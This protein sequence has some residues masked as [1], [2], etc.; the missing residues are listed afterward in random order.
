M[1][2]LP[3]LYNLPPGQDEDE[4]L[5]WRLG[6]HQSANMSI[7]GVVASQFHRVFDDAAGAAPA[8]RFL[9]TLDWPDRESFEKG[10]YDPQVQAELEENLQKISGPLF[11]VS[12][13][14]V[15]ESNES[16]VGE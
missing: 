9:T 14:L 4:F 10:F 13:C 8:Y 3:V 12:E 5:R 7:G 2:R 1:I 15:D 11:I 6:E 16:E